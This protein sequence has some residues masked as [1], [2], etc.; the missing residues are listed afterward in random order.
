[1]NT[2]RKPFWKNRS[3]W[4]VLMLVIVAAALL[5]IGR[6]TLFAPKTAP[7]E[8]TEEL[9]A[10]GYVYVTA[11]E[12][13][14]WFALPEGEDTLLKLERGDKVNVVRLTK[15][16]ALMD[17]STCDN[18]DCVEQGTV[19]LTNMADRVL[20]NMILCLPNEVGIQLFSQEE[21][22]QMLEGQP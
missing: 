16:G 20:A 11:G 9:T 10:A 8:T 22:R 14:R 2:V 3:L 19:T 21:M 7:V 13:G 17:S 4:L 12:E 5:I 18:Q 6:N 15:E 1:M